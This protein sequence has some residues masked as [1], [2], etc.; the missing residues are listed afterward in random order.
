[1]GENTFSCEYHQVKNW[2][3]EFILDSSGKTARI[4]AV[5]FRGSAGKVALRSDTHDTITNPT[6]QEVRGYI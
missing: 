2:I 6:I 1:M 4:Q 3:Q 5:P